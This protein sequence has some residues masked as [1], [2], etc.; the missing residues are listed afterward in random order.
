MSFMLTFPRLD[1]YGLAGAFWL[2]D[3]YHFKGGYTGWY[4][5]PIMFTLC[6]LTVCAGGFICV[7]GMYA[8][9]YSLHEA[10]EAG[11]LPS[12]FQC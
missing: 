4:K 10:S 6:V 11:E 1:T 12:P 5:R 9:I 8:T 2:H 3:T 7:G